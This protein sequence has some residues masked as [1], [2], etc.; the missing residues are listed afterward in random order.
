MWRAA[1]FGIHGDGCAGEL[2]DLPMGQQ[3][4]EF[5][6]SLY[7]FPCCSWAVQRAT[8]PVWKPTEE[9]TAEKAVDNGS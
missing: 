8:N 4:A 5:P 3:V 2:D 7:P 6:C 1:P 9:V